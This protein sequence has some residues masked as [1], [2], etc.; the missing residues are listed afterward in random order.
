MGLYGSDSSHPVIRMGT[1]RLKIVSSPPPRYSICEARLHVDPPDT[2]HTTAA[3]LDCM[4][5]LKSNIQFF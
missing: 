2:L 4:Y 1:Y 5:G 3:G